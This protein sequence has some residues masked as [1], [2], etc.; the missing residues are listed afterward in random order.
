MNGPMRWGRRPR[1][2]NPAALLISISGASSDASSAV[3]LRSRT[4]ITSANVE[5]ITV[6][7]AR[8]R[9]SIVSGRSGSWKGARLEQMTSPR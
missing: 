5:R 8:R 2:N 4:S 1:A 3:A 6:L 7:P 9:R